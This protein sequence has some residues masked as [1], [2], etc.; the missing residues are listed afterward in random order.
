MKVVVQD[1]SPA[2]LAHRKL[3]GIDRFDEMWEGVLH[4]SPAPTYEHQ[5][6]VDRLLLFLAPLLQRMGRGTSVTGVNI[7]DTS[8]PTPDYRIPDLSFTVIDRDSK[9]PE[10]FRLAGSQYLAVASD[11]DGGVTSEVLR[12]RLRQAS[13]EKPL[14]LA[15]DL[16]DSSC[17]AE[18]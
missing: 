8:S 14:L 13:S 7:F 18:I 11:R 3:T 1:M 9:R 6:M 12:V 15:E 4:M 16:D 10:V 2:A 5:R 17:R